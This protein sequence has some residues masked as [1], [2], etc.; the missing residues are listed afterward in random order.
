MLHEMDLE[1]KRIVI[2][3]HLKLSSEPDALEKK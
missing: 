1:G 2:K 3:A